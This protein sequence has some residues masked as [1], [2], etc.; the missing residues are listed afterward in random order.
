MLY[1]NPDILIR[2]LEKLAT[3]TINYLNA[4]IMAGAQV[5]MLFDTWGG[6]LTPSA[7]QQFSLKYLAQIAN[8]LIRE[9]NGR[10]IPI[11]FFTKNGGQ[12]LE[13]I[14]ENGCDAIGLDWTTD[15]GQAQDR[16]GDRVALQ[17][18]LDPTILLSN[19]KLIQ[20]AVRKI[21]IAYGKDSGHV[22][23]LGHGIDPKTPIENVSAM[24]EA[25]MLYGEKNEK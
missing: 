21:L 9:S 11:I 6:I 15:I 20:N 18:N 17:G 16:I 23:N 10:K 19:P 4:Q 12:W 22:F 14:A 2:L 25:V 1:Q 7:Y 3:V 24:I 13:L 5:I 8:G